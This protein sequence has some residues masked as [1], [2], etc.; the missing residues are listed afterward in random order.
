MNCET[1]GTCRGGNHCGTNRNTEMKVSASPAPTAI[2]APIA[3]GSDS[4]KARANCADIMMNAP[5]A[6][7]I[8][9]P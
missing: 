3:T 7:M 1:N 2:R 4:V 9:E 8:R 6:I 5:T